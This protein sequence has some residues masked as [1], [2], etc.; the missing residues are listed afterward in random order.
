MKQDKNLSDFWRQDKTNDRVMEL[1]SVL[2]GADSIIGV[3][4]SGVRTVWSTNG[5]SSTVW[6]RIAQGKLPEMRVFLDYSPVGKLRPPFTGSAVDE[7]I[8]YAAHEGGHCLWSSPDTRDLVLT[9]LRQRGVSITNTHRPH[10]AADR[11]CT[12]PICEILRIDNILEDAYIDFHVEQEWP[13]LGEYIKVAR[14]KIAG[15]RPIDYSA[16][17]QMPQPPRN[18][19]I[20]L[21]IGC[22]LY[23]KPLPD[24]MSARVRRAM[25]FLMGKSIEALKEPS[26]GKRAVLAVDCWQYLEKE[27]PVKAVPL[28]RTPPPPPPQP[29]Q[30]GEGGGGGGQGQ[31][32]EGGGGGGGGGESGEKSE[33]DDKSEGKGSGGSGGGEEDKEM[34]TVPGGGEPAPASEK[35][36]KGVDKAEGEGTD[37]EGDDEGEDKEKGEGEDEGKPQTGQPQ[38]GGQ[39]GGDEQGAPGN[40]DDFDIREL[41]EVPKELLEA[42][43]DAISHELEDLSA[44]VAEV[45]NRPVGN[46]NANTKRADYDGPAA[47]KVRAA[48]EAQIAEMRRVFDHQRQLKTKHLRGLSDGT[49]D[50]RSLARVGTGNLRVYK[51]RAVL[52]SPDLAVG[53]LLDVSGS[54]NSSMDI[55]WGTA[56][57]FSEALIRKQG[58]NFL[59]LTYTG[60]YTTV[61][62]TRICDRDMGR[63]CLGNVDQ[64]GGTPSGPAIASMHIL[65]RRMRERQKVIIHFTDGAPDDRESVIAAVKAARKEGFAVWAISLGSYAQM[66]GDQYGEGNW[67]TIDSIQELPKKVMKLVE[68]LVVSR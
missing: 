39:Q 13:V 8:G 38:P 18:F 35:V 19:I 26:Q 29:P 67:E 23:D 61:Q 56:C 66:L 49:L 27:F 37:A 25:A 57:V 36:D 7:I 1:A 32:Q 6:A 44:S 9:V 4:G 51:R 58:V 21:W 31:K 45:L 11:Y 12:C 54:M 34:D 40:L 24:K 28:P 65:M 50:T 68:R 53:L 55:V 10:N 17:A 46:V 62:T 14:G 20:N 3:M 43:M 47:G 60:G 63:L 15:E 5:Q 16:I 52:D 33:G 2:Q 30:Q 22:S 41:G 59:C 48:V 64:G 42:V